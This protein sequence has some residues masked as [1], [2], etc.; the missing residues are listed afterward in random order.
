MAVLYCKLPGEIREGARTFSDKTS[1]IAKN[2]ICWKAQN[3]SV[4]L[5]KPA[6]V[7]WKETGEMP[8]AV[9]FDCPSAQFNPE[10]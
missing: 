2:R 1:R 6:R 8:R 7:R 4:L 3:C 9:C 5:Y 10:E